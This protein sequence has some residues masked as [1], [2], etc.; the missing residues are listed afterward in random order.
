MGELYLQIKILHTACVVCSGALFTASGV[1]KYEVGPVVNLEGQFALY[2]RWY[3]EC[4]QP[5]TTA[6]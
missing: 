6:P 5:R 4:H 3:A 2:A 1:W